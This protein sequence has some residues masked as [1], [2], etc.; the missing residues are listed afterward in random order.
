MTENRRLGPEERQNAP[1]AFEK[2]L[3]HDLES[4]A[5]REFTM[6]LGHET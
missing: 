2:C 5:R 6:R 3:G 4:H 1:R